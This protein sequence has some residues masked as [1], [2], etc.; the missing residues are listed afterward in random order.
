MRAVLISI[1]VFQVFA[2][3]YAQFAALSGL[4]ID[5]LLYAA[6]GY[7]IRREQVEAE[8][9]AHAAAGAVPAPAA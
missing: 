7:M 3:Y 5:L 9:A 2:F 8:V 4:V 1:F 6:L